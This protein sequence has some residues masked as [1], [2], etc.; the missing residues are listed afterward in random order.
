MQYTRI[1]IYKQKDI[2]MKC[3][4]ALDSEL[5]AVCILMAEAF[6]EDPLHEILIP[7]PKVRVNMLYEYFH[8]YID[9]AKIRGGT[10]LAENN[11]G[12][13]VYF[14]PEAVETADED[15]AIIDTHIHKVC[16]SYSTAVAT[17]THG[18]EYYHPRTP[19]HYYIPLIAI[20]RSSRGGSVMANLFNAL[21]S[22]ADENNHPCYLECTRLRT[23]TH[24]SQWGY[25]DAGF[26]LSING[27]PELFPAWRKPHKCIADT[28]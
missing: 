28:V 9:L 22:M 7:D 19:P 21:H 27:F 25:Q 17:Y 10:L 23:R 18:L 11:A 5:D 14:R 26:T 20:Q 12:A 6:N 3:R 15:I 4:H 24:F 2:Y 1:F 13:L 16:G 8:I